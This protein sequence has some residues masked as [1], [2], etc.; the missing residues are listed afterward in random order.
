MPPLAAIVSTIKLVNCVAKSSS[1]GARAAVNCLPNP[2]TVNFNLFIS[3]L[4]RSTPSMLVFVSMKPSLS[5]SSKNSLS[6]ALPSRNTFT[7]SAPS[8]SKALNANANA[9]DSFVVL[10]I[11]SANS[12]NTCSAVLRLP[13]LSLVCIPSFLSAGNNS[14]DPFCASPNLREKRLSASA[15][16]SDVT[17]VCSAAN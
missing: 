7:S 10:L 17:P 12:N 15:A 2:P 9:S 13:L 11:P 3:S 4:N 1:T 6:P 5:A 16:L 14:P 8:L